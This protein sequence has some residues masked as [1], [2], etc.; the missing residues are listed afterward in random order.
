MVKQI[1]ERYNY[2]IKEINLGGGFG[3]EYTEN[4]N[5]KPFSYFVDPIMKRIEEF[6]DEIKITRPA[7]VI[8]PGRSIV[9]EAG[10]TL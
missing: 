7:I 9:G 8:E 1:K 10:I 3:I 6:F 2:D 4:D 5:K